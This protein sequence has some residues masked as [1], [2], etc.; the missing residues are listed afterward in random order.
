MNIAMPRPQ[1]KYAVAL[2]AMSAQILMWAQGSLPSREK[3][4]VVTAQMACAS[5]SGETIGGA[6]LHDGCRQGQWGSADLLQG[7]RHDR[8]FSEL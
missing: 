8:A 5:L 2:A 4:P 6:T 3:P 7:Q 1:V